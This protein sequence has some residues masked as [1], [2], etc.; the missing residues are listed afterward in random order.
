MKSEFRMGECCGHTVTPRARGI[1]LN[2]IGHRSVWQAEMRQ[3]AP[4]SP[5]GAALSNPYCGVS[6]VLAGCRQK[7]PVWTFKLRHAPGRVASGALSRFV[8]KVLVPVDDR[9]LAD[10]EAAGILRTPG[11]A[12]LLASV[13]DFMKR[14]TAR[15]KDRRPAVS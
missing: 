6:R 2:T 5:S 4:P 8:S 12:P 7:A 10:G 1:Q 9:T 13:I 15:L 11:V 3:P 14:S